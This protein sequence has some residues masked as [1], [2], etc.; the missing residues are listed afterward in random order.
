ML[1]I[2][3]NDSSGIIEAVNELHNDNIVIFPT[4][5]VYGIGANA[6][7]KIAIQKIYQLKKRPINNPLIVHI[8]NWKMGKILTDLSESENLI[9]NEIIKLWPGPLTILVKAS[10][11]VI[12][13]LNNNSGLI[14][15]RC[16]SHTIARTLISKSNVPI[17]AP[18]A[19]ISGKTSSTCLD[20]SLIHI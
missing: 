19:N 6:F 9:V 5:T 15:L 10:K 12:P 2:L 4:E 11:Y 18:S 13:E 3:N 1:K 20:L 14:G 8:L 7:S 17:A 16:P